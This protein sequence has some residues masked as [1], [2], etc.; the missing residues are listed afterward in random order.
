MSSYRPIACVRAIYMVENSSVNLKII[1]YF[2]L[3]QLPGWVR[4]SVSVCGAGWGVGGG[5]ASTG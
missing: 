4:G 1:D 2:E 3:W 5:G